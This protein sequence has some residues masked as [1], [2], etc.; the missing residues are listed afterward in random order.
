MMA[1]LG[2]AIA[3]GVA[4]GAAA[5]LSKP[6]PVILVD[7]KT[8]QLH[9]A[10]YVEGELKVDRTY[11]AT[12]GK[13]IGDKEDEGDLKTPE[14]IYIFKSRLAP[15]GLRQKFGAMAFTLDYP[16]AYDRIAGRTGFSIML[17][18]TNE[19]DRLK[20][21][22]DSEGCVVVKND[23]IREIRQHIRLGL[24]PI[25]IFPELGEDYLKPGARGSSLRQFFEGWTA[26]WE[27]RDVERYIANYHSEFSAQGKNRDQWKAYKAGLNTT[28]LTISVG[29]E[30]VRYYLHPKYAM[31]TFTQ[32]Y[33]ST[34]KGGGTGHRSRG[35]KILFVAEEQG[36][37]K[38]ISET[39]STLMW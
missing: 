1:A 6:T 10:S 35:T 25:L 5:P 24:T 14:G 29:P 2:F 38:I 30:D 8:N 4:S 3:M 31:I 13:V 34:V 15:P 37:P 39:Y 27:A 36:K 19:P 16:N 21:D 20:K 18:A 26:S 32:N 23:E 28:Y 12:L 7:K 11:H 22:Y 33:H 17:H 9:V